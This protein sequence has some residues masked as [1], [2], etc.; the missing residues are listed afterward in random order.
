MIT[1]K[2]KNLFKAR[3]TQ[4]NRKNIYLLR[5]KWQWLA[6]YQSATRG[7]IKKEILPQ[8]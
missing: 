7:E 1:Q 2:K 3:S 6:A 5:R 8:V 4:T